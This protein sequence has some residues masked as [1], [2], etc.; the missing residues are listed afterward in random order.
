MSGRLVAHRPLNYAHRGASHGAPANTLA[1]FLLAAELGADGAELDVHLSKDGEAVVIH[2]FTL[3]GTTDGHGLVREHT[4]AE[5]KRLDAGGWFG[6]AYSGERIPTLQEVVD[7]VGHRLLLNIEL[8]SGSWR[9]EGLVAEAVRIV[10]DNNIA[11]RVIISSFNPNLL[12]QVRKA[13]PAIPVGMLYSPDQNLIMRKAWFRHLVR[14]DALHPDSSMVDSFYA[15]WARARGYRLHV[16]TVDEPGAMR[17]LVEIGVDIIITN[18]PDVL[19][20]V[21]GTV[22]GA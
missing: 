6:A 4:L 2:D 15:S 13:N 19:R 5:L 21:L 18:R 20:E 16:W 14:P 9:D 12:L 1:A 11:D 3:E 7:A 10:E 17:E 22:R 8:K